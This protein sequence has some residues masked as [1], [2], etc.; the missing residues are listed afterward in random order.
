LNQGESDRL[1]ESERQLE[2]RLERGDRYRP[3]HGCR[4]HW[5]RAALYATW[6]LL[7]AAAV[8]SAVYHLLLIT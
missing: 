3:R 6:Y 5:F 8:V 4:R 7:L 1:V 2:Q